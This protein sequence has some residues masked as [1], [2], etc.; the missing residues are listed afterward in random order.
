MLVEGL[1][2]FNVTVG[3]GLSVKGR[4]LLG[5]MTGLGLRGKEVGYWVQES[6]W[7]EGEGRIL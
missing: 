3:E 5:G 2:P 1:I 7:V 6:E 4:A